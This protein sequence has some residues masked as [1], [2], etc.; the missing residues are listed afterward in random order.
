M[1]TAETE[2][3]NEIK[4]TRDGCVKVHGDEKEDQAEIRAFQRSCD[5]GDEVIEATV[6]EMFPPKKKSA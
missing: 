3:A 2:A 5:L 4:E 1:H 6:A